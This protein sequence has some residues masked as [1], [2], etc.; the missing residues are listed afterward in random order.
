MK[1]MHL[2]NVQLSARTQHCPVLLATTTSTVCE[3]LFSKHFDL[4]LL[5]KVLNLYTTINMV[6]NSL[7]IFSVDFV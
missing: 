6:L 5:E 7:H 4:S 3:E 2:R 1:S